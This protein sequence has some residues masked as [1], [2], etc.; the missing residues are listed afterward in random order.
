MKRITSNDGESGPSFDLPL[1]NELL[2]LKLKAEFGTECTRGGEDM[3]PEV[4]NEFLKSVYEFEHKFREPHS[5]VT[6]YEKLGRPSFRKAD[7]I[8]ESHIAK[9]L[10]RI[11]EMLGQHQ[12]ELDVL[13][14]YPDRQIYKFITEEFFYQQMDDLEMKGYIHHFCYEDFHPNYEMEIRQRSTE[15][16][17]QWFSRQLGEYSWQLADPFVHPDSREFSKEIILKRIRHLFD[18]YEKFSNCNYFIEKLTFEWDDEKQTGEGYVSGVA[19][20]DAVTESGEVIRYDG[21]FEFYLSN[22]GTWWSIF[23]FVFPGFTW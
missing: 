15:F 16:L 10:K 4:V 19:R 17:T 2:I 9:E 6:V 12:L 23:Y 7:T 3:P 22:S 13:G 8:P 14:E 11:N 1:E 18:A 21:P 20:Y 5:L